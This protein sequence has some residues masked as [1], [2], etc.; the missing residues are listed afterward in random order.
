MAEIARVMDLKARY[1]IALGNF[2]RAQ[3]YLNRAQDFVPTD[4]STSALTFRL[5]FTQAQLN[6]LKGDITSA[7][8]SFTSLVNVYRGYLK[9]TFNT[10]TE[11]EKQKFYYA[12][13]EHMEYFNAF[14]FHCHSIGKAKELGLYETLY[15]NQIYTKALLVSDVNAWKNRILNSGNTKL[16]AM[17]AEWEGLRGQLSGLYYKKNSETE[18]ASLEARV[19]QMEKELN[20]QGKSESNLYSWS[21]INKSLK[22]SEAAL[23]IIRVNEVTV[24]GKTL[25]KGN[26]AYIFLINKPNQEIEAFSLGNGNELENRSARFYRNAISSKIDDELSYSKFW[27]PVKQKLPGVKRFYL[28]TDGVYTQV[29][30][31][32][33]KNPTTGQYV[34]DEADIVYV[35]N[36]R[37]L[38]V[39]ETS[40]S[41]QT[42]YLFGRPAYSADTGGSSENTYRSLANEELTTLA[43][44]TFA[45]LPGTEAEINTA[46]STLQNSGWTLKKFIGA[47]ASEPNVKSIKSPRLLHI[48]THGFFIGDTTGT[49]NPMIR[50]G[51]LFSGVS[52]NSG[53]QDG[54]LTAYEA[55]LL[56]LQDTELVILSACETGLGEVRNGEGVYGLQRA[57]TAAGASNLLMSLWKVDDQATNLL[58][59]NFY[60][61]WNKQKTAGDA[62]REAQKVIRQKYPH[63]YYWGAFVMLG[64]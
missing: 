43:E 59:S 53:D 64:K 23:E 19:E 6:W 34:L 12:L 46:F 37:D 17:L 22:P 7:S 39:Q 45:D 16:I 30:L 42:A 58:M 50:S 56:N 8:T 26:A 33:I 9:T 52:K 49:V 25:V 60:Q 57:I 35:T 3:Q 48:A 28:S 20:T 5:I 47:D 21:E 61:G 1:Q 13:K 54:I 10:L 31:N 2:N 14:V 18:I 27:S 38:L 44:Q 41:N 4:V 40:K 24:K 29:N 11:Y 62:F 32:T 55:A 63:P 15:D 51:L 36:T